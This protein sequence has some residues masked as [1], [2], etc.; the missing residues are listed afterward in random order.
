DGLKILPPS[1]II[2]YPKCAL[3]AAGK[4]LFDGGSAQIAINGHRAQTLTS[5]AEGV[6]QRAKRL[7]FLGQ[8][9]REQ[10]SP[11]FLLLCQHGKSGAKSAEG[12]GFWRLL[13]FGHD[14]LSLARL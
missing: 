13:S 6:V 5:Q 8:R 12:F 7:A 11:A 10:K 4:G 1:E 3:V 2:G 14:K 9:A